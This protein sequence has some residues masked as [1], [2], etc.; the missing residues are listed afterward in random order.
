MVDCWEG[1][2]EGTFG[3]GGYLEGAEEGGDF[4]V[5]DEGLGVRDVFVVKD[6]A[7][8][9]GVE[10]PCFCVVCYS[11]SGDSLEGRRG[12]GEGL[13]GSFDSTSKK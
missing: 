9:V 6:E 3:I 4:G 2:G 8:F 12:E 11:V 13:P 10:G 7:G 5:G 1:V